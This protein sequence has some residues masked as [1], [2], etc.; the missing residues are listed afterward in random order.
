[1]LDTSAAIVRAQI[2]TKRGSSKI[3][4]GKTY[5]VTKKQ[6]EWMDSDHESAGHKKWHA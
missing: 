6:Y 1:M 5:I 4:P 2:V 3:Y